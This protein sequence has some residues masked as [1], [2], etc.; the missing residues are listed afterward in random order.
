[1]RLFKKKFRKMAAGKHDH[2]GGDLPRILS[3]AT[4]T[5]RW[6]KCGRQRREECQIQKRRE[7]THITLTDKNHAIGVEGDFSENMKNQRRENESYES[8]SFWEKNKKNR[9]LEVGEE[10]QTYQN[11]ARWVVTTENRTKTLYNLPPVRIPRKKKGGGG[12][13]K[14]IEKEV[15][16][17]S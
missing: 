16:K 13:G 2:L 3:M 14:K 12:M 8:D 4:G 1:M 11:Y 6:R 5:C 10:K 7:S 9:S 17:G 15:K